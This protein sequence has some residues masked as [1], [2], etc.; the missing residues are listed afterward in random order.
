MLFSTFFPSSFAFFEGDW[1]LVDGFSYFR[2][3]YKEVICVDLSTTRCCQMWRNTTVFVYRDNIISVKMLNKS[4]TKIPPTMHF[5]KGLF[6]AS[7]V[8]HFR[9]KAFHNAGKHNI[10]VQ[11]ISRLH[12]PLQRQGFFSFLLGS[13]LNATNISAIYPASVATYFWLLGSYYPPLI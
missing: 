8:Y 12:E 13:G 3:N 1:F 2:I 5:L 10:L 11:N 6:W 9:I 7:I 4:A